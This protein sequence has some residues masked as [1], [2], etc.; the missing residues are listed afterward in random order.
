MP[1]RA[2]SLQYGLWGRLRLASMFPQELQILRFAAV[3]TPGQEL[4]ARKLLRDWEVETGRLIDAEQH[5]Q[6]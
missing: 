5:R 1:D 6:A 3:T 4:Q 2:A